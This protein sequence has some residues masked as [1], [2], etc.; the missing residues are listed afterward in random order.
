MVAGGAGNFLVV[1]VDAAGNSSTATPVAVAADAVAPSVVAVQ[2]F[3]YHWDPTQIVVRFS[4]AVDATAAEDVTAYRLVG[5]RGGAIRIASV[6]YEA[7]T[8]SVRISP[9][10]RLYLYQSY[11]LSI[12]PRAMVDSA[13]NR[14]SGDHVLHI[15]RANLV[16]AHHRRPASSRLDAVDAVLAAGVR[17]RRGR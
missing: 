6:R 13:G 1:S 3:G 2:R 15:S 11:R 17:I 4:E 9:T 10:S 7:A 14:P 5:P 8:N 12:A 16:A